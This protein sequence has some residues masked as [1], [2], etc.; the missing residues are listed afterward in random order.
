MKSMINHLK[1]FDK[2]TILAIYGLNNYLN[3]Q[4]L[5]IIKLVAIF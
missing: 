2:S 3:T 5:K 1:N 4:T